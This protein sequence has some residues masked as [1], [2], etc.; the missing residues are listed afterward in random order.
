MYHLL[1]RLLPAVVLVSAITGNTA[2]AQD[3]L[4]STGVSTRSYNYA[5]LQYLTNVNQSNPFLATGLLD[6]SRGFALTGQYTNQQEKLISDNELLNGSARTDVFYVGLLYHNQL[7]QLPDTDWF[8]EA[9]VG[10]LQ[11]DFDT[12]AI[13]VVQGIFI[14]RFGGGAR[15]TLSERAEVE[16]SGEA[17]YV[18]SSAV[19][20][21]SLDVT[22]SATAVYRVLQNIDIAL[23]LNE[24]PS[25]NI[26]ALGVRL[27]W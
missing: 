14:S 16:V 9:A 5:E 21:E 7:F 3:I 12:T 4:S 17:V 23:S 11:V 22:V 8:A 26:F 18:E 25:A 1:L 10:R 6:I 2:S 20:R 27:T 24:V 13:K 15:H 19:T